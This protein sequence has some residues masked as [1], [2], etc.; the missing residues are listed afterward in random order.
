MPFVCARYAGEPWSESPVAREIEKQRVPDDLAAFVD[1][2]PDRFHA[3]VENLF[4]HAVELA[5]CLFVHAQKSAELLIQC[6]FGHHHP[7]VAQS[8]GEAPHAMT[9]AVYRQRSQITP[10]HL[11][12]PARRRLEPPDGGC[13]RRLPFRLQ[14][15]LHRRIS[16]GVVAFPQLT[17]QDHSVPDPRDQAV[18]NVWLERIQQTRLARSRLVTRFQFRAQQIFPHRLPV[19]AGNLADRRHRQ[20]LPPQLFHLIHFHAP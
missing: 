10:V 6:R 3:V 2:G 8:E 15:L 7:A 5:E 12:L 13:A 1:V 14:V 11:S 20:S 16:T 9:L 18:F 19:E 17:R 4:R